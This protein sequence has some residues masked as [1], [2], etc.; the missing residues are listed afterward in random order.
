V[1]RLFINVDKPL[2]FIKEYIEALNTSI[3][4]L[5]PGYGL[6]LAQKSWVG[7]CLMG[8]I[9]TNSV[10]W[11]KFS[12]ASLGKLSKQA[13]SMMFLKSVISWEWERNV[14]VTLI[15]ESSSITEGVLVIDDSDNK[16]SKS[17]KKIFNLI[18]FLIKFV[19]VI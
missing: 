11:A 8:I 12:R 15:L 19:M 6:T 4:K 3:E 7:F 5:R 2:P 16:R 9:V 14:S 17:V 13:I 1:Y 18:K 10:C